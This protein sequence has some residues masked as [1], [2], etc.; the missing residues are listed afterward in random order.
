MAKQKINRSELILCAKKYDFEISKNLRKVF[1]RDDKYFFVG[2]FNESKTEVIDVVTGEAYPHKDGVVFANDGQFDITSL[3]NFV[4]HIGVE[5]PGFGLI[6][7]R[8]KQENHIL[9]ER[10]LSFD[11]K[12]GSYI[13]KSFFP[14]TEE[15]LVQ[16]IE[17]AVEYM[18]DSMKRSL[19]FSIEWEDKAKQ[20]KS[21]NTFCEEDEMLK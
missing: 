17:K 6:P 1:Y 8:L 2:K 3:K 13:Y 19:A 18:N 4:L 10:T 12:T 7:S 14:K 11:R 20:Y 9:F 21:N 15:V 16:D 5:T